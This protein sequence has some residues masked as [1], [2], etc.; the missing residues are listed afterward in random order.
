MFMPLMS[1]AGAGAGVAGAAMLI[2]A[3]FEPDIGMAL[4][5]MPEQQEPPL[6]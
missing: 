5:D 6:P 4:M 3:V 2:P 1:A